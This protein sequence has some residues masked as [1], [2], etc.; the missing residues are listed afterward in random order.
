MD[1]LS[2]DLLLVTLTIVVY[3]VWASVP[4]IPAVVIYW[5]FP[6]AE[7]NNEWKIMGVSLR[8]TGAS[9]FYFAILALAYFKFLDPT[10]DYIKGLQQPFWLV[11]APVIFYDADRNVINS[12]SSLSQ[13]RVKPEAYDFQKIDEKS[14]LVKLRFSE[15][16]GEV[17][18]NVHLIFPEGEGFIK[19]ITL[20][21]EGNTDRSRKRIDLTREKPIEIRPPAAG[22]QNQASIAGFP[23][24]L[25]VGLESNDSAH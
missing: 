16:R 21:S 10:S 5:F 3:V 12:N 7:T 11:D 24:K 6:K 23:H 2:H 18:S 19:L 20:M 22:G 17:P 25:N 4:L 15:L 13:L 14:Y 1:W 8:A 9:G